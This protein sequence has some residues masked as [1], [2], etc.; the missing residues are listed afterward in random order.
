MPSLSVIDEPSVASIVMGMSVMDESYR[1]NSSPYVN[2]NKILE[3]P[4]TPTNHNSLLCSGGYSILGDELSGL[5]IKT[6]ESVDWPEP[7][8]NEEDA[9]E[10]PKVES[11]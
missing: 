1:V 2:K 3:T 6:Q 11:A 4:V 5:K 10:T 8:D 9:P 7:P